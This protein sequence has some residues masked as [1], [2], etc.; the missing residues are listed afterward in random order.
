MC[1]RL[2]LFVFVDGLRRMK[3]NRKQ[4][5]RTVVWAGKMAELFSR[6]PAPEIVEAEIERIT[7]E[8]AIMGERNN[9]V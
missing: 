9:E 8:V 7:L 6:K 2:R 1:A 4:D 5:K 3:R